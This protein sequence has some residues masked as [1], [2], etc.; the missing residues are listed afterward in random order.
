VGL[1]F[2]ALDTTFLV[3]DWMKEDKLAVKMQEIVD[4]INTDVESLK[5]QK[6]NDWDV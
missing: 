2:I 5:H 4:A 6:E 3:M 1:A